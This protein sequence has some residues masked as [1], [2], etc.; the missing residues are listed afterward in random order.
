[1]FLGTQEYQNIGQLISN[2]TEQA[3]ELLPANTYLLRELATTPAT[4]YLKIAEGCNNCCSYCLI[5]Q[6]RGRLVSR[7]STEIIEE[8][9]HLLE[10]GVK[11][12]VIIAQDTTA[13]GK[14]IDG[15]S[16]LPQLLDQLAA[17]PFTWLRLLYVYPDEIDQRL[18]E[19]MEAH[20]NICHYLD[21]PL[22]HADDQILSAMNRRSNQN[23]IR[24]K[25]A[26]I[27]RY[28][29]DVAL[30]TTM[31]V[32]FPGEQEQHFRRM[33]RFIKDI[34]FDWLGAFC[35][36]REDDTVAAKLPHQVREATKQRR[37]KQLM[38][39]AAD[40][41]TEHQSSYIGRRLQ[42]ICEGSATDE[43]GKGWYK[44]RSSYQA[45][46]VDGQVYFQAV[47]PITAGEFIL[48]IIT[49]AD[50]YDLIG[51]LL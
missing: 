27:R 14:D 8:A 11:E 31:M 2:H 29:P 1:L 12:L 13:Y 28:L 26:L 21:I 24:E 3:L 20:P 17:L 36:S 47:R 30:R 32:G 23:Q 41:S 48:V 49:A 7:P 51:E 44:G 42:I 5:P 45:P 35:Y 18:L 39:L 50:T 16:H 40:I 46:E 34:H 15:V 25:V 38:E 4:A 10:R 22:Q 6:L 19:V 33:L 37:Q 9:H 43:F